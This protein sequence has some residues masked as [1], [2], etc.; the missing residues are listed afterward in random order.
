MCIRDSSFLVVYVDDRKLAARNN[1]MSSLWK[2]LRKLIR[3]GGPEPPA[4][5][6]GCEL[7]QF[8]ATVGNFEGLFRLRPKWVPR[9]KKK[10]S[11]GPIEYGPTPEFKWDVD[12]KSKVQGFSYGFEEYLDK[13]VDKY[14]KVVGIDRK[15]LKPA[16][17]LSL[18]HI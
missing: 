14:C 8:E 9:T 16:L 4:R 13:A 1:F 11:G 12:P 5:Y 10:Q 7:S 17:N 6:L 2:D 3:M 15:K 18:I